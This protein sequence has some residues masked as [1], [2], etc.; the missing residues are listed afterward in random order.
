MTCTGNRKKV[1]IL[2]G[3]FDPIHIGHLMLA[4]NA[5]QICGLDKVLIMPSGCSYFKDP[6]KVT[7]T[8]HRV[9]MTELAIRSNDKFELSTIESDRSGN[10][11]TYETL[12]E[13]CKL[14]PDTR[15][16]YIIGADTLFSIETWRK[17]EEIFNKCTIVCACRDSHTPDELKSKADDLKRR[18]D[19][20][21][22]ITDVPEVP[23]S[24]TMVR[25][26]LSKGLNCRYYLDDKVIEYIKSNGLYGCSETK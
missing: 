7:D 24:S 19:A 20:D 6:A 14:N 18:Y 5:R 13:L 4:E 25:Q 10:S 2:G 11:Y 17:P 23:V 26:L 8:K 1:G 15:Y 9:A 22:T 3:T 12:E 21:I 16:Y